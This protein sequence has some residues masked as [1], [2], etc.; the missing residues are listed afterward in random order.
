MSAL[1][2]NIKCHL[3]RSGNWMFIICLLYTF[4]FIGM[5]LIHFF[6]NA[7]Y[8][9]DPTFIGF[10]IPLLTFYSGNK[11][12]NRWIGKKIIIERPGELMVYLLWLI[13]AGLYVINFL[14]G[15]K[16]TIPPDLKFA[17]ILVLSIF[18]TTNISKK[19]H[20]SKNGHSTNEEV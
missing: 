11:E 4:V 17:C 7:R 9:L 14:K 5:V 8:S 12:V 16:Y 19:Y 6:T 2:K 13:P 15:H 18:I 3:K 20:T 1:W 10:Y